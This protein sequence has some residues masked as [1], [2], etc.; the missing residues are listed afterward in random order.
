MKKSG[1][2]YLI[3]TIASWLIIALSAG[4]APAAPPAVLPPTPTIAPPQPANIPIEATEIQKLT[5]IQLPAS[6]ENRR[7]AFRSQVGKYGLQYPINAELFTNQRPSAADNFTPAANTITIQ[8]ADHDS[9]IIT[10]FQLDT[11]LTLEQFVNQQRGCASLQVEDGQPV[12]FNGHPFLFYEDTSCPPG[13]VTFFYAVEKDRGYRFTI[14]DQHRYRQLRDFVEPIL[15]TFDSW[16][17]SG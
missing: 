4:C 17:A 1:T 13:G 8:G 16:A 5:P 11:E 15:A 7:H 2:H 9:L 3:V 12:D 14:E 6:S 10:Y